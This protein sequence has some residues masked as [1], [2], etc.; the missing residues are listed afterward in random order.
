[1]LR[2]VTFDFWN[3][4]MWE[5]PGSLKRERI[6]I[7][8]RAFA[9][10]G[11]P[12]ER[13]E[14]ERGHD[15]AHSAYEV[16]WKAGRQFRVEDAADVVLSE[17]ADVRLP[18]NVREILLA[19]YDD[20]GRCAAVHPSDGVEECLRT[21]RSEGL[22]IGVVCDIGLTPSPVVR[23]LLDRE[24]LL[25]YFDH[26]GFSDESGF[27]K[28]APEAFSHALAGLGGVAPEHA[29][30]VGDR[31]RT[32]VGGAR[33]LGMTAVRYNAVY[34]DPHLEAG[35]API[36]TG[37]LRQVPALLGVGTVTT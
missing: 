2:A 31:L 7:W 29:A 18:A 32:D 16:A 37:D 30:H 8:T 4:L 25:G 24:G 5:E 33:A 11:R 10:A 9:E 3:T 13:G 12:V 23:E 1:M 17:L 28:P 26:A 27:Y 35:E 6:R 14:V 19:G 36:V 15:A 21:L 22:K 34:D 20:A